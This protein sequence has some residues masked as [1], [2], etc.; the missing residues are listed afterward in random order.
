M[1]F[2][3]IIFAA[4][5]VFSIASCTA[6][7]SFSILPEW[8]VECRDGL[9]RATLR[10]QDAEPSPVR[11]LVGPQRVPLT[12]WDGPSGSTETGDWVS[13][14]LEFFLVNEQGA[15][16]GRVAARVNCGGLVD[17][18]NSAFA[19]GSYFPLQVGN[20][21][22]YRVSSRAVTSTYTSWTV[23]RT[24]VAGERTFYIIAIDTGDSTSEMR[25]RTDADGRIYVGDQLWLD[26]TEAPN[27]SAVLRIER[28]GPATIAGLGTFPDALH[29][30]SVDGLQS[31]GGTFVRGLGLAQVRT[32]SLTGSS[33][34]FLSGAELVEARIGGS[35]R[36]STAVA[37]AQLSA[38][39]SRL[40]VTG[41]RVTN[42]AVPSYC[43]ACSL[44]P[45]VDPPGTY[46]P[47]FQARVG[48]THPA[49]VSSD[50]ELFN[51]AGE[52]VYAVTRALRP[53]AT[54]E[55]FVVH[56]VPLYSSPNVPFPAG[57][58]RLN[59]T[60]RGAGD[61]PAATATL[62]LRIE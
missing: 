16:L 32:D 51:G 30:L 54:G 22:T 48:V 8:I 4:V 21:W 24:E 23:T 3:L 19:T 5:L 33:G 43:V 35:V 46:K 26:P 7:T 15:Q 2:Y 13:D 56:Q 60:V 41:R 37:T 39:A 44:L 45:G 38:E 57:A 53:A 49:A 29:Y 25:M 59:A 17:A 62:N 36:L 20:R 40:D 10:W 58:Y 27:A 6:A 55:A 1:R 31:Q 14:G 61:A 34:G 18:R 52:R 28:R 12:G 50:I 9:G 47:C 42:C 11:V